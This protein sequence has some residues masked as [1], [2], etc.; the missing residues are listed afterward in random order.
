MIQARYSS[1]GK[2]ILFIYE[3]DFTFQKLLK[4]NKIIVLSH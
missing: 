1:S 3:F 2:N 4:T